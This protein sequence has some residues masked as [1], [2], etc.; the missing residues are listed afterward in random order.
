MSAEQPRI[1][2][3][4][5]NLQTCVASFLALIAARV[6][7]LGQNFIFGRISFSDSPLGSARA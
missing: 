6:G 5:D 4:I 7:R 1:V 2:L 3:E